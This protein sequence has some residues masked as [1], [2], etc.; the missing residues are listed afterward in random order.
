MVT[1]YRIQ[2]F[3]SP[4][5]RKLHQ[6]LNKALNSSPE[7]EL[8]APGSERAPAPILRAHHGRDIADMRPEDLMPPGGRR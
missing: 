2:P 3:A 4:E 5:E 8:P 1:K 6:A 7:L